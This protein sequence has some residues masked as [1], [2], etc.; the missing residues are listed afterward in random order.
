MTNEPESADAEF[1]RVGN[2]NRS[3]GTEQEYAN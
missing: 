3:A 1:S 2:E